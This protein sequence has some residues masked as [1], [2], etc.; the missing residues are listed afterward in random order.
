ML[1]KVR[2]LL[3]LQTISDQTGINLAT[4]RAYSKWERTPSHENAT[5][6]KVY[7]LKVAEQIKTITK[8]EKKAK[9]NQA[10]FE[11][12]WAL[13]PR[14]IGKKAAQS[15]YQTVRKD[16]THEQIMEGLEKYNTYLRKE[17]VEFQYIAHPSTWLNQGRRDDEHKGTVAVG[18]VNQQVQAKSQEEKR[19]MSEEEKQRA[20]EVINSA[21]EKMLHNAAM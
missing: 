18:A 12:F 2:H 4:L 6:L 1:K 19:E 21:R 13:Y 16:T 5:K 15:K 7:F 20:R 10:E 17:R 9:V 3:T 11:Q 14:K 8:G